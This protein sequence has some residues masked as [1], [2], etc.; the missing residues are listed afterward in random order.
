MIIYGTEVRQTYVVATVPRTGSS[1][2]CDLLVRTGVLG[3]PVEL[4][5]TE[6]R[7]DYCKRWSIPSDVSDTNFLIT[8]VRKSTSKN[9]VFGV[10]L[11]A[12]QFTRLKNMG[13]LSRN[14]TSKQIIEHIA[15]NA[16]YVYLLRRDLR[17]QGISWYRALR[18]GRW[19]EVVNHENGW[20]KAPDPEYNSISI[21]QLI[22]ESRELRRLWEE[23]FQVNGIKPLRITYE[24]LVEDHARVVGAILSHMDQDPR[25]AR[26]VTRSR[27]VRLADD[28]SRDWKDRLIEE[29]Q[30]AGVIEGEGASIATENDG[31][32]NAR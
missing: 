28:I 21:R 12:N 7:D 1:F 23:H 6:F 25:I 31:G 22:D 20:V 15:P 29:D 18:T 9:G 10:K 11:L 16:K 26:Y 32:L 5:T 8:G 27:Y 30:R 14:A 3:E 17:A 4:A 2:L 24:D 19:W 13:K